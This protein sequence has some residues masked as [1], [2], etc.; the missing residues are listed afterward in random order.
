MY[1]TTIINST[2]NMKY[3]ENFSMFRKIISNAKVIM[4]VWALFRL[5]R[6]LSQFM[7]ATLNL[8]SPCM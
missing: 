5:H 7:N 8:F 4:T 3:H 2:K 1:K 6:M